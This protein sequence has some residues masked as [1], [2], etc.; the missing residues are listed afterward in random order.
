M[1]NL[2]SSKLQNLVKFEFFRLEQW[3]MVLQSKVVAPAKEAWFGRSW[4]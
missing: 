2:P 3:G 1:A 4:R